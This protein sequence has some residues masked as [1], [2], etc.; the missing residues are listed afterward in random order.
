MHPSPVPLLSLG[1]LVVRVCVIFS[2]SMRLFWGFTIV[3]IPS[4]EY[5]Y[6]FIFGYMSCTNILSYDYLT[7]IY[8]ITVSDSR[9]TNHSQGSCFSLQFL[10]AIHSAVCLYL[11]N[12]KSLGS[13][14]PCSCS[15]FIDFGN[16]H[17]SIASMHTHNRVT[18]R[19]VQ[20][21]R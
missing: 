15:V 13:P 4:Q 6:L 5:I 1:V 16:H 2:I 18:M 10:A 21:A 14:V 17:A 20:I 7:G 12:R 3:Y 19:V 9:H 8:H 11:W